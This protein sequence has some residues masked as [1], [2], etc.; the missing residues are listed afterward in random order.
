MELN[1]T[2]LI[3]VIILIIIFLSV[4]VVVVLKYRK[5]SVPTTITQNQISDTI[6]EQEEQIYGKANQ[7]GY[8]PGGLTS[9]SPESFLT[10]NNHALILENGGYYVDSRVQ[11]GISDVL[12]ITDKICDGRL[13]LTVDSIYYVNPMYNKVVKVCNAV[14]IIQLFIVNSNVYCVTKHGSICHGSNEKMLQKS[15]KIEWSVMQIFQ[16]LSL[17]NK[18]VY[19][20]EV[21]CGTNYSIF[22]QT[23]DCCYAC[24]NGSWSTMELGHTIGIGST[25]TINSSVPDIIKL[26]KKGQELHFYGKTVKFV[27]DDKL[28]YIV[29]SVKDAIINPNDPNDAIYV[30]SKD[31]TIEYYN[32]SGYQFSI[33]GISAI[34]LIRSG[35]TTWLV[36]CGD[37]FSPYY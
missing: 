35:T 6:Y 5:V 15:M 10:T 30:V 13:V 1:K 18:K 34:S 19:K 14:D 20:V 26:G 11:W 31:N 25:R 24:E 37:S 21:G 3:I 16:G 32:R 2:T 33:P 4:I 12:D 28:I 9:A 27:K 7:I 8:C 36:S 17:S 29:N 22:V 23:D